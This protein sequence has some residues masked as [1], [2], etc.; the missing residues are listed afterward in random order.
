[1][2]LSMKQGFLR[3]GVLLSIFW[4]VGVIGLAVY[5]K[6]DGDHDCAVK[7]RMA[8]CHH[9]YFWAW[10]EPLPGENDKSGKHGKGDNAVRLNL[11]SIKLELEVPN[12]PVYGLDMQ[13]LL[14]TMFCPLAAFWGLFF[15]LTWC[16]AGFRKGQALK[17]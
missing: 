17:P 2:A 16:A 6:D 4:M 3:V 8:D 7:S 11:G 5:E 10:R 13:R 9:H 1:M 15:G 12:P 14:V